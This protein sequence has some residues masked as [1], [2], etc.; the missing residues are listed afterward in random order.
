MNAVSGIH[1]VGIRPGRPL[2]IELALRFFLVFV[3]GL[4]TS[5]LLAAVVLLLAG[6]AE[7][8]PMPAHAG[9][10]LPADAAWQQTALEAPLDEGRIAATQERRLSNETQGFAVFDERQ[11][12]TRTFLENALAAGLTLLLAISVWLTARHVPSG[13]RGTA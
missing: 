13:L 7:A 1:P 10:T 6:P 9:C 4:A 3:I 8:A 2:V 12:R 5:I 11:A